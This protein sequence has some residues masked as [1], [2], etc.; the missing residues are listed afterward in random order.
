MKFIPSIKFGVLLRQ[1]I[2]EICK[3]LPVHQISYMYNTSD[4]LKCHLWKRPMCVRLL[5]GQLELRCRF[6]DCLFAH[7]SCTFWITRPQKIFPQMSLIV[8]FVKLGLSCWLMFAFG[9]LRHKILKYYTW[10]NVFL[11]SSVIPFA[12]LGLVIDYRYN[13]ECFVDSIFSYVRKDIVTLSFY[14]IFARYYCTS[15]CSLACLLSWNLTKSC[16]I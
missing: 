14:F 9:F 16:E 12:Y 15:Q 3:Y 13:F 2:I 5:I 11:R 7:I 6:R 4:T 8:N 10:L 1:D